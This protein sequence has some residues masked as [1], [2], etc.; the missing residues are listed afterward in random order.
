MTTITTQDVAL[1]EKLNGQIGR[2]LAVKTTDAMGRYEA[3]SKFYCGLSMTHRLY[4]RE[5]MFMRLC[6]VEMASV[7]Q[8]EKV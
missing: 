1:A 3:I 5:L 4:A 8:V 6:G 7:Q 2:I